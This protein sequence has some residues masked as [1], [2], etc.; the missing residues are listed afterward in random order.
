MI[1]FYEGLCDLTQIQAPEGIADKAVWLAMLGH[2]DTHGAQLH[3][4]FVPYPEF[5]P[6]SGGAHVGFVVGGKTER[7][8]QTYRRVIEWAKVNGVFLGDATA[9]WGSPRSYIMDPAGNR[10]ELIQYA[11]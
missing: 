4:Y 7:G 8:A 9:Y 6:L 2:K 3:I 5:Q 11:P 10:V 1:E